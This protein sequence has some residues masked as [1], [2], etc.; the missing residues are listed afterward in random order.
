MASRALSGS[1]GRPP[2]EHRYRWPRRLAQLALVAVGVALLSNGAAR[3]AVGPSAPPPLPP[4]GDY[5]LMP[6]AQLMSL[7]TH[8]PAWDALKATADAD[9]GKPNLCDQDTK[10][11]ALA[12]AGALVYARTGDATYATKTQD[13]IMAAIGTER[14][15]CALLAIGRQ[16][17]GY[18]LAADFIHLDGADGDTFRT[19]LGSMR[20]R[21][22]SENPRWQTIEGTDGD[23]ANNWGAFAGASRIAASLYVGDRAD[24]ANAALILHGFLGDRSAYAGFRGQGDTNDILTDTIR[25][26][27]CD[28]SPEGFVPVNPACTSDGVNLDGAIVTDVS[29]DGDGLTWPVGPTGIGYTLE[30][31]QGLVV[32]AELLYENGYPSVWSWSKAAIERAAELVSRNGAAGGTSWNTDP[33]NQYVPWLLNYRY[34]M[35]APTEPAGHGRIFGYTDWLYGPH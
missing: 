8:G 27:A 12:L 19:W 11:D 10:H 28:P 20:T 16:L 30:S 31:L 13:A 22:F 6:R 4:T 29:R 7:P 34:G 18:V 9:W 33:V 17:G 32:Q 21:T 25:V 1:S 5:L 3:V 2:T 26:W 15:S 24:V 35:A 14:S 23:S